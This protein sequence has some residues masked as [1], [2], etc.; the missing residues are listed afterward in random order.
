MNYFFLA[1]IIMGWGGLQFGID[2]ATSKVDSF[3][4]STFF[5]VWK[6]NVTLDDA[7]RTRK[8][9]LG[10]LENGAT[11]RLHQIQPLQH[12]KP[13]GNGEWSQTIPDRDGPLRLFVN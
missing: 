9:D 3:L 11:P 10:D 7:P 12:Y 6:F 2:L 4:L 13:W 8:C 5:N 1:S